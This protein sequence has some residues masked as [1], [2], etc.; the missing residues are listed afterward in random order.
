[1]K[2]LAIL[3]STGSIGE[4]TLQVVRHLSSDFSISSLSAHS[5]IDILE[6]QIK[7]FNVPLAAV[8]D[9]SKAVQL[10]KRLPDVKILAGIEGM[11]EIASHNDVDFVVSAIVGMAALKPTIAAIKAKKE[12]GLANKEVLVAAGEY[13]TT[14]ARE[15]EVSLLPI[16]S[17]HNAIFQCLLGEEKEEIKRIIL[18]ASGGPFR[19]YTSEQLDEVDAARALNHPTW[20]MG[21]KVTVDSST[22][23]NKGL[24]VIEARW[25]FDVQPE[26]VDVV[27]HPQ[28]IIHSMVE[29]VDGSIKAQLNEPSMVNPIQNVLTFPQRKKTMFAPFDLTK[30]RDLSF[31]PPDTKS[32]PCLKLAYHALEAGGSLPCYMN[33]ANEILVQRFLKHQI[34]WKEISSL[35]EKLMFKQK[36]HTKPSL[37]EYLEVDRAAREEAMCV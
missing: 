17:E 35:L 37:S 21:P 19:G 25:L 22:L 11:E 16:D 18:T 9:H 30:A 12:I 1:M 10:Q 14:L 5:N 32:F 20:K 15:M 13:V 8:F 29:F 7:E 27:I 36:T 33:A 31:S 2:R 24:E 3:G 26:Q 6:K 23:M 4:S 28:S 34:Q